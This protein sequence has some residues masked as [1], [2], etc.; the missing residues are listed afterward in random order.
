M[1]S[2][3]CNAGWG[4]TKCQPTG[5]SFATARL[6][7]NRAAKLRANLDAGGGV[8]VV[9]Q[10]Q[11]K[12]VSVPV[13]IGG[14]ETTIPVGGAEVPRAQV[15]D[16]FPICRIPPSIRLGIGI[17]LSDLVAGDV[18]IRVRRN[19]TAGRMLTVAGCIAVR[20]IGVRH[21][22]IDGRRGSAPEIAV[23]RAIACVS[24]RR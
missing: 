15:A 6:T 4:M 1:S 17:G 24:A 11:V 20:G 10:L 16:F 22:G 14:G 21:V 12:I 3:S 23:I 13:L 7:S 8:I 19:V 5:D 9:L 2:P 18:D